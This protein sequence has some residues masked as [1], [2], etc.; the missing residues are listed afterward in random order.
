MTDAAIIKELP[1]LKWRGLLAPLYDVLPF[2]WKN[3]LAPRPYPYVDVEAHDPTGR[4]SIPMSARLYFINTV[5]AEYQGLGRLFPDYWETWRDQLLDG[6]AGDLEHPALGLLRARVDTVSGVVETKVQSGIIVEVS[7]IETNEDP[8]TLTALGNIPADP[9]RLADETDTNAAAFGV[10]VAP[11]RLPVMFT[12]MYGISFPN[13]FVQPT[14][15]GLF[16]AIRGDVF[17]VTLTAGSMLLSLMGDVAAMVSALVA[18]DDVTAWPAIASA[19]AFWNALYTM[20]VN[21]ARAARKT[22]TEV[23]GKQT[24]LVAFAA[25]HNNS[26]T[27]IMALNAS[28]LRASYVERGTSLS[29]YTTN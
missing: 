17:S 29:Y 10:T 2:K 21:I 20:Q 25:A 14:L 5:V 19:K 1:P 23:V 22:A 27:E 24:T 9:A 11:G 13:G 6:D 3:R 4:D 15:A 18:L 8:A 28:A 12:S 16:D 26:V 7:W